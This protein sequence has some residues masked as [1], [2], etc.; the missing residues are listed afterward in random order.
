MLENLEN[1]STLLCRV[2]GVENRVEK[3]EQGMKRQSDEIE[4]L[5]ETTERQ[6]VEEE[7]YLEFSREKGINLFT[8]KYGTR[9]STPSFS[10]TTL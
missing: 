7:S 1:I 8:F 9:Y 5:K 6:R 4:C 3:M 10:R 2:E